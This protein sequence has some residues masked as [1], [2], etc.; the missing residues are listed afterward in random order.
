V[1]PLRDTFDALEARIKVCEH[2]QGATEEVTTL[3]AAIAMLRKD[4]YRLKSTNISMVFG[5]I[6]IPDVPEMPPASTGNEDRMEQTSKFEPET[7]E[8]ILE[9]TEGVADEDLTETEA[10]II[11]AAV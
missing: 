4:V 10:A 11:D 5:T 2:D 7:D 6:E 9:D 8:E 3:K 1:T